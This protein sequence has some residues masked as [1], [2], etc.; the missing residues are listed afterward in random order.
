MKSNSTPKSNPTPT[1][2]TENHSSKVVHL[3]CTLARKLMGWST[4]F[5]DPECTTGE[6]QRIE[7]QRIQMLSV[8]GQYVGME[9]DEKKIA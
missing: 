4:D 6:F 8:L 7:S 3:D 2:P 5:Q 9:E 1:P